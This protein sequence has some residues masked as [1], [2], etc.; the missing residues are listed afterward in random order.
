MK[1][2]KH[3]L[4]IIAIATS[5]LWT[6]KVTQNALHTNL[7]N[8]P[9]TE[10][11][12]SDTI[13]AWWVTATIDDTL[14]NTLKIVSNVISDPFD[15]LSDEEVLQDIK[16][17]LEEYLSS[18]NFWKKMRKFD[19]MTKIIDLKHQEISNLFY[20]INKQFIIP[21][22]THWAIPEWKLIEDFESW[23]IYYQIA[24]K[25]YLIACNENNAEYDILSQELKLFKEFIISIQEVDRKGGNIY[26]SR[27]EPEIVNPNSIFGITY[28]IYLTKKWPITNYTHE[29][30]I[31]NLVSIRTIFDERLIHWIHNDTVSINWVDDIIREKQKN[32]IP[33][34]ELVTTLSESDITARYIERITQ[35]NTHQESKSKADGII[36]KI[37]QYV[38]NMF[39]WESQS[40][41]LLCDHIDKYLGSLWENSQWKEVI[42][43]IF[44]LRYFISKLLPDYKESKIDKDMM[45]RFMKAYESLITCETK[46]EIEQLVRY[47]NEVIWIERIRYLDSIIAQTDDM[48]TTYKNIA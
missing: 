17:F 40:N 24:W 12:W 38:D 31:N 29:Q 32:N 36:G 33:L 30:Y 34:S 6:A 26:S 48:T 25:N 19:S 28:N 37:D 47:F 13:A 11:Q 23:Y 15:G 43:K 22:H 39:I 18:E 45:D 7:N 8:K 5:L 3:A 10:K 35:L 14:P 9:W 20:E 46:D 41:R 1:S 44:A 16:N 2:L 27:N 42:K 21:M 4:S